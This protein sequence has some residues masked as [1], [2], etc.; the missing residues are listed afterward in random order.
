MASAPCS[1]TGRPIIERRSIRRG[2]PV[3]MHNR[4][5]GP[6]RQS[7][8]VGGRL[9]C[10]VE[11]PSRAGQ[12]GTVTGKTQV[13]AFACCYVPAPST[14][15]RVPCMPAC[16]RKPAGCSR[17]IPPTDVCLNPAYVVGGT[18]V[19]SS[20]PPSILSCSCDRSV[21]RFKACIGYRHKFDY[22]IVRG[23]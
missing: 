14:H 11:R 12:W 2:C 9:V 18:G 17:Q 8:L 4:S 7:N 5:N 20:C 13:L 15:S 23:D 22:R 19:V 3:G 21:S 6:I 16:G 10:A 1:W